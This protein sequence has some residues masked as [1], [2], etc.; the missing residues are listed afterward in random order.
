M[1][2]IASG[3][4]RRYNAVWQQTMLRIKDPKISVPFYEKYFGMEL[5]HQY[6]FPQWKFSLFFLE[7]R[8]PKDSPVGPHGGAGSGPPTTKASEKYL[9]DMNGPVTLELTH[10]HG[11]ETDTNF[12]VWS[13]NSGSD[14]PPESPFFL[15][16]G[17]VRGFGHIAFNVDDVYAFSEKLEQEGVKFQKRP[18][19]G[20][21]KGLAFAL[22]PDGYWLELCARSTE[23][24][25]AKARFEGVGPNLSQTM[26]RVKGM[27]VR[28]FF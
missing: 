6:D 25:E 21:M 18:N 5:V 16:S 1:S 19:E 4:G 10:N 9:W 3:I 11:S 22:D 26:L 13:G 24:E 7:K 23:S 2:S 28:H 27:K 20:R 17:P 14:L 15:E 8:H 12:K